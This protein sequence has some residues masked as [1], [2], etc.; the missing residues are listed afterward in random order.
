MTMNLPPRLLNAFLALADS[1][2]F[3]LAAKRSHLSQSAFSQAIARLETQVGARLFDR[4]TRNVALTPEGELLLP[5]ARK[6][7]QDIESV[8]EDL[9]D[10]AERRKG[11]VAVA[12]LP[13]ASAEWLPKI[14]A[15]FR[16]RYPGIRVQL[17]DAFSDRV[18]E[19]VRQGA[20]DFALNTQFGHDEEFETRLLYN[21][22]FFLV[23]PPQ[24]PLARAKSLPLR[25]LAGHDYI[26]TIRSGSV[27]QRL[28][29][30]LSRVPIRDTGLEVAYM[31]TAAGL[32]AH[33]LGV[34]VVTGQ[35]LFNFRRL[36]L[37]AVP[38][39]DSGLRSGVY[40]VKRRGHSL[41]VAARALLDLMEA[42]KPVP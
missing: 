19:L 2:Q 4:N 34:T 9:R 42:D 6:L 16:D 23:C 33:G 40:I 14:L 36:G 7:V 32:V 15:R 29:P 8:L 5:A 26:H 12:A 41:S 21:D 3:T 20:V 30:Y 37:A 10:H 13:G 17:H 27:W 31:S 38:I 22:R 1:R 25:Q 28:Q 39:S 11:K 18:L 24:H 35:S